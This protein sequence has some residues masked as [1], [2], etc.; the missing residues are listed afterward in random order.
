VYERLIRYA[1]IARAQ[2][3]L[4]TLYTLYTDSLCPCVC[5]CAHQPHSIGSVY[6]QNRWTMAHSWTLLRTQ[7]ANQSRF[8]ETLEERFPEVEY[9]FPRYTTLARPARHRR[10]KQVIKPVY[11][12]YIFAK[13]DLNSGDQYHITRLPVRAFFIKFGRDIELI[14]DKVIE[15]IKYME[16]N[17]VYIQDH[18]PQTLYK[19]GCTLLI[20]TTMADI[21]ATLI[22]ISHNRAIVDT[23][24]GP[25]TVPLHQCAPTTTPT[26]VQDGPTRRVHS[27]EPDWPVHG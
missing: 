20:H 2:G 3:S 15:T 6:R 26:H 1:L 4:Y 23:N 10:P 7:P 21:T 5:V 19:A 11:P 22:R 8:I 18:A 13:P 25:M 14:P 9:Y 12:G 24:L 17:L 16:K 27:G